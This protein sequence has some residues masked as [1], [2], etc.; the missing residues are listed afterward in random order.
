[1]LRFIFVVCV[2]VFS[3]AEPSFAGD[4]NRLTYLDDPANPY[5][6]GRDFPKLT[7]PLWVGEEGVEAVVVLAIDD[8]RGH[9]RWEAYLRPILERLKQID[10]R[11]PVSIMTCSID[12][13][14]PHLQQW[15]REGLSLEVHTIDHP[16][17]LLQGGDFAKAKSTYDRCVDLL[18]EVPGS[19]PVAFRTPCCD[20]LN[21]VSPRFFREIFR[22][23]TPTKRGDGGP[24]GVGGGNFLQVDSSVFN[25][26][27][28]NDPALPRE[29]VIDR[30]GRD[31]FLKYIPTDRGFVNTVENYPYPYV[32]DRLC[33]EFPCVTPSDWSAQHRQKPANPITIE[34]WKAALDATVIKQG[35]F[36]LVFHPYDWVKP[37]QVIEL[38]NH[39]VNRHGQK[40]KFL[41]FREALDRLNRNLLADQPLRVARSLAA[42][43]ATS[44]NRDA[45]GTDNN[46]RLLDVNNDGFLD[47]VLANATKRTRVWQSDSRTWRESPF[48]VAISDTSIVRFGVLSSA[49]GAACAMLDRQTPMRI[50]NWEFEGNGWVERPPIDLRAAADSSRSG[51]A[52]SQTQTTRPIVHDL[53]L[54]DVDH[55]GLC[56]LI[57]RTEVNAT[58]RTI[59]LNGSGERKSLES[60]VPDLIGPHV[61]FVDLN[62]DGFGD[63]ITSANGKS[64]VHLFVP[65]RGW[66]PPAVDTPPVL[67]PAIVRDDGTD[68]GFFVHS[69]Q[70]YWQNEHT[71][72]FKDLVDRRAF[73]EL[74][75]GE[76]AARSPEASRQSIAVRPGFVVELEAAEPLVQDPIG[77]AWGPDGKL[78]VVE[79][80]DY[81][82]GTDG[83][84]TPGG[85]VRF[86]EDTDGDGHYDRSTVFLDGIGFPTGVMP[87]RSGVL[88]TCAPDIF[89]AEDRDGDG[90]AD[91]RRTL[92]TGFG[93]GNQQHRVNGLV[94]G[95]DGWVYGANGDSG[96]TIQT[97]DRLGS[98]KPVPNR[99]PGVSISG[100]DFRLRPDT[101]EFDAQTGQTQFGRC[102]D[103]WGNW[104]GCNN[105]NPMYQFVLADHYTRR[106]P[107]LAP[108]DPRVHVSITPGSSPVYPISRTLPRFNDLFA[109]NRFTSAN[110]VVVY[111]DDLFGPAFENNW[112]VS[113]PVHN[114][115]HREIMEPRGVTFR[116]QR[117]PDEQTSEFL[118]SSDNWFRPTMLR[119]GP[120]GA[121]WIADMYRH[122][123]EHPE[124]IPKEQQ[125]KLDLRAGHDR[126]RLYRVYPVGKRPRALPRLDRLNTVELVAALDSPSGWQRDMAQM[127][128]LWRADAASIAPLERLAHSSSRATAR[129]HAL[130]TLDG[131]GALRDPIVA[132]A[133]GDSHAGVR[134]H[135]VRIAESRFAKS[136]ELAKAAISLAR[137]SD[138]QVRLQLAYSLGESPER[139][140][141]EAL[142]TIALHDAEDP[143]IT[144]A[145]LSSATQ[146]LDDIL[147]VVLVNRRAGATETAGAGAH[148]QLLDRLLTLAIAQNNRPATARMLE[149]V[150]T[151]ETGGYA[152]WQ[153]AALGAVVESLDRRNQS[154]G[155]LLDAVDEASRATAKNRLASVCDAARRLL[156][157]TA[158][159]L[160]ARLSAA[161][162]VGR[163]PEHASDDAKTL[164]S[165]LAPQ[166]PTELQEAAVA[167]IARLPGTAA[168][169]LLLAGW[170][171][172]SPRIR[173]VIVDLLL[174]REANTTALL[175]RIAD[176]SVLAGEI[177]AVHRPRLLTH[178]SAPIRERAVTLLNESG[179]GERRAM[180]EPYRSVL[181]TAGDATRGELVFKQVCAS[182]HRLRGIGTELGPDLATLTD[183]TPA[184]LLAAILDPNRAMEAR[185][186]NYAAAT[187]GGRTFTGL[188][189]TE[190]GNSI[191]LVG[192][193]G[194]R[195]T[196]LRSELEEL[197]STGTSF[198][199]EGL[200][201]DLSPQKMA[202]VIAF[203]AGSGPPR[204]Q[205]ERNVPEVVRP[206]PLRGELALTAIH[207]EIYGDTLVFEDKYANLGYWS[208]PNDHAA[209]TLEVAQAGRYAVWLD[210]ACHDDS[211]G[212]VLQIESGGSRLLMKVPGTGVWETYKKQ[213]FGEL[214][215][216]A[217]RVR[218]IARPS[219][220][221]A[222]ALVDLQTIRLVRVKG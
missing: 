79:M 182:C 86:L 94:W 179:I 124:W 146:N 163:F 105:P 85:R 213:R 220:P 199:P 222:G 190:T 46:V 215:L 91:V 203:V 1:M 73:G 159:P 3:L 164:S 31:R 194:K 41:T 106:N 123:I 68:N 64:A 149:L 111:R 126:G 110:S 168:P 141:A 9:E 173:S 114:L 34:D 211:A 29:L 172:H 45:A 184:A 207:A 15:L 214:D 131:L 195:E 155:R 127:L 14:A 17:P 153:F 63:V 33:W 57:V 76:P 96:G 69:R 82:L 39:A 212:N 42:E 119:V 107:H 216:P 84:G 197:R 186:V 11:A 8:M 78:W 112:F 92:F 49:G 177:G 133:F 19:S 188:L 158:R 162:V 98:S 90:H 185:F 121:L 171:S 178:R 108:P 181:N 132:R 21:T 44:P 148:S 7:T 10:G 36:N 187:K 12:P 205:F 26:M 23:P 13:K 66:Q 113:E 174:A 77:F 142:G 65:G 150:S 165:L 209:W 166:T 145:V 175:D 48:P 147:S 180:P 191:T 154:L 93:A 221:V 88:V 118:A 27:T 134:R 60:P 170:R 89:F 115:V 61:R 51:V 204:K 136:S 206:D 58:A 219:G 80:G 38:I 198:M 157:D 210:W 103:D 129:L 18:A 72:Q 83:K 97:V 167:A 116:S 74:L 189:A 25:V 4:G 5:Y 37:Q 81:P 139:F 160:D 6:V 35:T 196:I 122:V 217:G 128:L 137:D 200:E 56:E 100:R 67:F 87:W 120:D 208:S 30:D 135:A 109:F 138:P 16:C 176:G 101:G 70:L 130:C 140:A 32:I 143:Y 193:E 52:G 102:S 22:H 54:R 40:V 156:G 183:R 50:R 28:S 117:A 71:N 20:S 202:D 218:L 161:R 169:D 59:I 62:E 95:V 152:L 144:A 151:P 201:R 55:D 24:S 99:S 75:T 53:Q 104:F 47:V 2:A 192:L 43:P 125:A